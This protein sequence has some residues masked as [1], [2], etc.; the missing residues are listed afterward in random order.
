MNSYPGIGA[1][2]LAAGASTRLGQPK[3]LLPFRGKTLLQHALDEV[4]AV[5]LGEK[6]LVLGAHADVIL[7]RTDA[8]GFHIAHN[9]DWT[10]GM[11]GSI[12][13]GLRLL[14]ELAPALAH[15]LILLSDQPFVTR[16][17]LDTLVQTQLRHG[18]ITASRYAGRSAVPALFARP[19]FP[20]LMHLRG[21]QGARQMFGQ[22]PDAVFDVPFDMGTFDID[23]P[24]DVD[25]LRRAGG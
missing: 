12:C 3:Q 22:H 13:T 19:Y 18:Q 20:A 7:A 14:Q 15:V 9:P 1:I 5:G 25:R 21:D 17:L 11:A 24:A 6:V 2:V 4:A 23:T 16:D 10:S 8:Q